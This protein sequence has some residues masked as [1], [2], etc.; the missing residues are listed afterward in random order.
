MVYKSILVAV[1]S[2]NQ[3]KKAVERAIRVAIENEANLT[4][5]HIVDI[6]VYS[7]YKHFD[8]EILNL[9]K[10]TAEEMVKKFKEQALEAGV[11][12]V[13]VIIEAGSAKREIIRSIIPKIDPDLVVLGATGVN[14]LERV[15][16]GSVSE[17]IIRHAPV[18]VLIVR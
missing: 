18:D 16:V 17:Y 1:D 8:A 5:S 2:S 7:D 9:A 10:Q 14:A 12:D 11:T 4:I 13:A 6:P 3:S 15:L